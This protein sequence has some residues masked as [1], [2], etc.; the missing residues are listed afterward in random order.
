MEM[1]VVEVREQLMA[2]RQELYKL[3]PFTPKWNRRAR[4]V[5]ALEDKLVEL[6]AVE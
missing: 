3:H 6:G 4:T 5:W 2:A 1:T